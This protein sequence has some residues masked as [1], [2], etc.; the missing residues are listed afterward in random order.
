MYFA[1]VQSNVIIDYQPRLL[2]RI[3]WL[4]GVIPLHLI[5][6]II[7][8]V[9]KCAITVHNVQCTPSRFLLNNALEARESLG[10]PDA[11]KKHFYLSSLRTGWHTAFDS[12]DGT[13]SLLVLPGGD[14][15]TS[16]TPVASFPALCL[17]PGQKHAVSQILVI[18]W[19]KTGQVGDQC[20]C[21]CLLKDCW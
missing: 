21:K 9:V 18:C 12:F 17:V 1:F 15:H 5:V 6:W 16:E 3:F 20:P 7:C 4:F 14:K 11:K 19:T 13:A 8:T 2:L 10:E